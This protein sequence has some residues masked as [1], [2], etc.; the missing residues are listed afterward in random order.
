MAL[1]RIGFGVSE[2]TV[3]QL[4]DY[5]AVGV[6]SDV[7]VPLHIHSAVLATGFVDGALRNM[8]PGVNEHLLQLVN[9]VFLFFCCIFRYS[10]NITKARWQIMYAFNLCLIAKVMRISHAKFYCNRLTVVQDIQDYASLIFGTHCI[11]WCISG[12]VTVKYS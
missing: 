4:C 2:V 3:S 8:V 11:W 7:P 9:A 10:R 1:N 5:I 6:Q 12:H